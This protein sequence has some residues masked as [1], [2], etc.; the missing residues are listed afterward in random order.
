ML[1]N[2]VIVKASKNKRVYR[3][4]VKIKKNF[5]WQCLTTMTKEFEECK[6]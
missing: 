6:Y 4:F 3:K 1:K 5:K 2:K